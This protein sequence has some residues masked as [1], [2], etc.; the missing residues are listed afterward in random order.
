MSKL[1]MAALAAAA[2][3]VPAPAAHA[4]HTTN[5]CSA[6]GGVSYGP[7]TGDGWYQTTVV[8]YNLGAVNETVAIRCYIRANGVDVAST[9]W[10]QGLTFAWTS[11]ILR[12]R[13]ATTL[14]LCTE[15]WDWHNVETTCGPIAP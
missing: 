14:E 13:S 7:V 1:V 10:R 3:A 11:D 15:A 6:T 2:L 9:D 5:D 12:Y 8:G 4:D